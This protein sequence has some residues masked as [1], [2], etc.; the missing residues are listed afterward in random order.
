[1]LNIKKAITVSEI[2]LNNF[3]SLSL[4]IMF[5][6]LSNLYAQMPGDFPEG[7]EFDP[8]HP[9]K[10]GEGGISPSAI[11]EWSPTTPLPQGRRYH[12]SV[13]YN[14]YVYVIGG[15]PPN[16]VS[17][18]YAQIYDNGTLGP[19]HSTTSLPDC[20]AAPTSAIYNG[21]L[22]VVGGSFYSSFDNVWYA[23]INLD[24]T[25]GSWTSSTP[26]PQARNSHTS[27]IH[28]GYL[29][30]IGGV[31]GTQTSTVWC[32]NVW[33]AP[34]NSDGT[35]GSW[36]STTPLPE[37]RGAHTSVV[38]D[39][40]LYV[41]GG[42]ADDGQHDD[43]WYAQIN[44]DGSL[45]S[46]TSTTPLPV[47]KS[48]HTS[49]LY[50]GYIYVIGGGGVGGPYD[51]RSVWYAPIH[52]DGTIGNWSQTTSLL[53]GRASHTSVSFNS[54]VYAI[55]GYNYWAD[56][57]YNEV[58]YAPFVP[59]PADTTPPSAI[60]DLATSNPTPDSIT[61]TWTAPGDDGDVGLASQ[62]DIRYSTSPINEGNWDFATQVD[63]EP[64]PMLAG[65]E[66]NF[67]VTDLSPG[68]KYFAIK[69]ADEVPN[70]SDLSNVA[71]GSTLLIP[72]NLL[73]PPDGSEIVDPSVTLEWSSVEGATSYNLQ[74]STED[75]F[76]PDP[77]KTVTL[78]GIN[79]TSYTIPL[80]GIS[81][82]VYWHAKA[83]NPVA[84]SDWSVAWRF[85]ANSEASPVSSAVIDQPDS[86][87]EIE[88]GNIIRA[89]VYFTGTYDGTVSG[90]WWL[91]EA[92]WES[93]S[94]TM[95]SGSRCDVDSPYLP[96]DT[97]GVTHTLQVR[98]EAP[99]AV[100]SNIVTYTVVASASGPPASIV[101]R[102]EPSTIQSGGDTSTL[103][104]TVKDAS[105]E[106]VYNFNDAVT[107]A[108]VEG[109][110]ATLPG[111]P[112]VIAVHGVAEITLTSTEVTGTTQVEASIPPGYGVPNGSV[113]VVVIDSDVEPYLSQTEQFIERLEN[114]Q[115]DIFPVP[116]PLLQS[117]DQS[118]AVEFL[119]SKIRIDPALRDP[120]D[121][122]ALKRLMLA[123][124]A[125]NHI[126]HYEDASDPALDVPG[127]LVIVDDAT[128]SIV[129]IGLIFIGSA[130]K[131]AELGKIKRSGLLKK[132]LMQKLLFKSLGDG[133]L[134][135][136]E[137]VADYG[138]SHVKDREMRD[139]LRTGAY[140]AFWSIKRYL[141]EGGS[142][143]DLLSD[144]AIRAPIDDA[145]LSYHYVPSTQTHL[146]LAVA[147]ANDPS[148]ITMDYQIANLVVQTEI[149][150]AQVWTQNTHDAIQDLQDTAD[151]V[152]LVGDIASATGIGTIV[153]VAG[154]VLAV[155][156]LGYATKF[157]FDTYDKSQNY[158]RRA[159][160]LAFRPDEFGTY[161]SEPMLAGRESLQTYTPDSAQYSAYIERLQTCTLEYGSILE[162]IIAAI[163]AD[164][165]DALSDLVPQLLNSDT[166][167][168]QATDIAVS[169]TVAALSAA[170]ETV[171][172]YV[173]TYNATRGT[174]QDAQAQRLALYSSLLE[175]IKEP[176][177]ETKQQALDQ[178]NAVLEANEDI[179]SQIN[180]NVTMVFEVPASPLVRVAS[181]ELPD[182]VN[183]GESFTLTAQ[184]L[185]AG[186]GTAHNVS[187]ELV[188][189]ENVTL[190]SPA[191][192][193]IGDL[194][195]GADATVS[196]DV[197]ANATTEADSAMLSLMPQ[198]DDALISSSLAQVDIN[199]N[200][201][202][203]A[204]LQGRTDHSALLTFELRN[205]GETTP[206]EQYEQ[207]TD[208]N[209]SYILSKVPIGTYDVTAKEWHYLKGIARDIIVPPDAE[210][211]V[212]GSNLPIEGI[213]QDELRGGD[214]NNDNVVDIAD[215]SILAVAWQSDNWE[216]DI[217]SDGV[218]DMAD[219]SILFSNVG[220]TGVDGKATA[221]A[222]VVS[223]ANGLSSFLLIREGDASASDE[224]IRSHLEEEEVEISI[225]AEGMA[226]L[227]S[228]ALDLTYDTSALRLISVGGHQAQEKPFLKGDARKNATLFLSKE[229]EDMLN[230][231]KTITIAGS[232]T[233]K[234]TGVSG[235]GVV[236]S[237]RF[238]ALKRDG[239][240]LTISNASAVDSKGRINR[241]SSK[242]FALKVVPRHSALLQNFPNPFNPD[243]WIPFELAQ[244]ANVT[245]SIYNTKGQL[246][247]TLNLGEQKAGIY[248]SRD[249]AAYWDGRGNAGEK[250]ASGVYFYTLQVEH[251]SRQRSDK[252][253]PDENGADTFRMTRK[254]VILK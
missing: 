202:G 177:D 30:V 189:D 170:A 4:I 197:Q 106:T 51:I 160:Y 143:I 53:K 48:N 26:L 233:G 23:P 132:I 243:T 102:A 21:Y 235:R 82:S 84:F 10:R 249:K 43:V 152:S 62:Y 50:N 172:E 100:D 133:G 236:A 19:W 129:N 8:R 116:V 180:S 33:Y 161:G 191:T 251:Q 72:P 97:E 95:E 221:A 14:G 22:Y 123:E 173:P 231:K 137:E 188:P 77:S 248:I 99:S 58:E 115:I 247:R 252:L 109:S 68:M 64:P 120:A 194:A 163:T 190:L 227:Y 130:W 15:L 217:N 103:I 13:E 175:Y 88:Q 144:V 159:T 66:E 28:N 39:G 141:D 155:F 196:W 118:G 215:F 222:P 214:C 110:S 178:A 165:V 198:A 253:N 246:I 219:L 91:D 45:G 111:E 223:G 35:I 153:S 220:Y 90:H 183:P 44:L 38:Y 94:I 230:A 74:Y 124:K 104:A 212:F 234:T 239:G 208:S 81:R 49:V 79:E 128:S 92:E 2:L 119:D 192:V 52:L 204:L 148:T 105:D 12:T 195:N 93:F 205:P 157:A 229:K 135:I 166:E 218:V 131:V 108:V 114:L 244:D 171:A 67:V 107:F 42:S 174:K 76:P 145:I 245:I 199:I 193:A 149:S 71:I 24:G 182:E 150:N 25:I 203:N 254:M 176:T 238:K 146:D 250:V 17:V 210:G 232:I 240:H 9:L 187:V 139:A 162:Q 226:D 3:V 34:M 113:S 6:W 207:I 75:F 169:P 211:I 1:M 73:S 78:T 59:T 36:A 54:Y 117:Y 122:E 87:V 65:C 225:V 86:G 83:A 27:V 228:F 224:S 140:G 126:Y 209:G 56:V 47:E 181:T 156:E 206:V 18:W 164:D 85:D 134:K 121:I 241:L 37:P 40:S 70:W 89:H 98:V 201:D 69:T 60:T 158:V 147:L 96:T 46:W 55:G 136:A 242:F 11:G 125:L 216:A 184:I 127:A 5:C 31:Y 29:Y 167:L 142:L 32:D 61:L 112:T 185:N 179:N 16:T 151:F 237:L 138:I 80:A 101:M 57:Y 7:R 200:I 213:P 63:G 186:S 168:S 41:I 154:R 20:R